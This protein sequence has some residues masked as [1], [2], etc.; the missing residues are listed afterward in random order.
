MGDDVRL[1]GGIASSAVSEG[2]RAPSRSMKAV[3]IA[4]SRNHP[5]LIK[6]EPI[7]HSV[8]KRLE[9]E[10][11]IIRVVFPVELDDIYWNIRMFWNR[12]NLQDLST[13][14]IVIV[15]VI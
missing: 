10:I 15:G 4:K 13:K 2:F 1:S 14:S 8:S 12:E 6:G 3:V 7:F 11:C 9:A 5:G